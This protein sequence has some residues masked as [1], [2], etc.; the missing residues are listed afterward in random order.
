[1]EPV[2]KK[3]SV[4]SYANLP[5]NILEI[6][7]EKY[8]RGYADYMDDIKK[9][10]KIDGSYLYAVKLETEDAVYLVKVEVKI[11]DYDEVEKDIFGE[12]GSDAEG[13]EEAGEYPDNADVA[14][15]DESDDMIDD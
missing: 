2:P 9:I 13:G 3:R 4:I 5:E 1:M 7:K 11:D 6:W 15:F 8:P 14:S 10:D 12:D